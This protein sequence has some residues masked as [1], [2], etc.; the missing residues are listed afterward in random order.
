MNLRSFK[1]KCFYISF[2]FLYFLYFNQIIREVILN[3][4]SA[5]P[6]SILVEC[7]ENTTNVFPTQNWIVNSQILQFSSVV[8]L[9]GNSSIEIESI[10]LV[11]YDNQIKAHENISCLL[12]VDTFLFISKSYDDLLE[13]GITGNKYGNPALFK[14]KCHF[15]SKIFTQN[16]TDNI[17]VAIIDTRNYMNI[18]ENISNILFHK[19]R[20]FFRHKPKKQAVI[21]CVHMVSNL[22]T[23]KKYL[24][25]TNWIRIQKEIGFSKIQLY[26]YNIGSLRTNEL[27]KEFGE[28]FL[29][30]IEYKANYNNLCAWQMNKCK[31]YPD[32]L[33]YKNLMRYCS[34]SFRI[35][36]DISDDMVKNFHE[37]LCTN[38][39]LLNSKYKYEYLTNYDFDEI[40]FPRKFNLKYHLMESVNENSSCLSYKKELDDE[41]TEFKIYDYI[42][43]INNF[44]G[45]KIAYFHFENV[46]FLNNF[47]FIKN[48]A[49]EI[50]MDFSESESKFFRE[51]VYKQPENSINFTIDLKNDLKFLES[52]KNYEKYIDCLNETI[53]EHLD[54]DSKWNN[55]FCT[56]VNYRNG[57]SVYVT[58]LTES[59]NQHLGERIRPG[60]TWL[61]VPIEFGFVSHFREQDFEL[62]LKYPFSYVNLDIEYYKFLYKIS[63]FLL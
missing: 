3:N 50:Y 26:L 25:L 46:L 8:S 62:P 39:C 60:S 10:I 49:V 43:K 22:D 32:S 24:K 58:D 41:K 47:Q 21:N 12:K 23:N 20:V 56:L 6:E 40:I 63:K 53:M 13:H 31:Q 51:I 45:D 33:F 61:R 54:S 11:N 5:Q 16:L 38:D 14:I 42:R 27:R 17:H 7:L 29:N 9:F 55:L 1:S 4:S 19:P 36:F 34:E 52:L 30:L 37:R 48:Q 2:L 59:L 57:K 35:Y 28:E 44:Y 15:R 18:K